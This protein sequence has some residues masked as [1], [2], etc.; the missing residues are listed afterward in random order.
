MANDRARIMVRATHFATRSG[1]SPALSA[2]NMLDNDIALDG[3]LRKWNRYL[4]M[5]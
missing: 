4:Q 3:Q 5:S 1:K 2:F